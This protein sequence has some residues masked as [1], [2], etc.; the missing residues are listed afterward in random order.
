VLDARRC[1]SYLTIENKGSIPAS[2]RPAIGTHVYGCD[3]C[4]EVCPFNQGAP[5]AEDPVWQPRPP[6]KAAPLATL[7]RQPDAAWRSLT[8]GSAMTRARVTGLRRNL[9]VAIGNSG[10]A[11]AHAALLEPTTEPAAADPVVREHV[12]WALEQR[13]GGESPAVASAMPRQT[14]VAKV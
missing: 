9:A 12:A 4:Q 14:R 5:V 10:D 13:A 1:I 11:D 7:W 2:L 6:L 3:I 8:K